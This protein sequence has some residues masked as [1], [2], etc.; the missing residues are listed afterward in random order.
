[1]HLHDPVS[2]EEKGLGQNLE[3]CPFIVVLDSAN[4]TGWC[5]GAELAPSL[6]VFCAGI[7]HAILQALH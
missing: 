6:D 4:R 5:L 7:K 2:I 3:S 1:M